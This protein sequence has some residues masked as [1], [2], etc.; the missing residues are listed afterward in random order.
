MTGGGSEDLPFAWFA[1]PV[2]AVQQGNAVRLVELT[3]VGAVE[4]SRGIAPAHAI[5]TVQVSPVAMLGPFLL[6]V[7]TDRG[8]AAVAVGTRAF[9]GAARNRD[10]AAY[11][12][13]FE[14]GVSM[15]HPQ[16]NLL[17]SMGILSHRGLG[18]GRQAKVPGANEGDF[19]GP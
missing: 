8:V 16:P 13:E 6:P 3:Q 14:Y 19:V 2:A 15:R 12:Q 11:G 5:L 1:N 17:Q 7:S 10:E 4:C 9:T 18:V